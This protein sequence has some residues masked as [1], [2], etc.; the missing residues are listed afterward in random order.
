MGQLSLKEK[1]NA[2]NEVRILASIKYRP[3]LT[4]VATRT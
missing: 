1:E 2:V 3:S 4:L